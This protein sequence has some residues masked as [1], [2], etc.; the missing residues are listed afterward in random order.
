MNK[1][2]CKR[3]S[4]AKFILLDENMQELTCGVTNQCGELIFECLPYGTYYLKEFEA[5]C[6]YTVSD[7]IMQIIIDE[8]NTYRYVECIN[9]K[10][11]GKIKVVKLG[12]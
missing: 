7:E 2:N 8:D 3:L 9:T 12:C 6:G 5:P 11:N 4:G 10:P 1:N